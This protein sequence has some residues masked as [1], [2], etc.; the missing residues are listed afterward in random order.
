MKR[1]LY[2]TLSLGFSVFPDSR[3]LPQRT[4]RKHKGNEGLLVFNYSVTKLPIYQISL[5]P[6][7]LCPPNSTQGH[8]IH[9]RI[10]RGSQP[11]NGKTRPQAGDSKPKNMWTAGALACDSSMGTRPSRRAHVWIAAMICSWD[12][13]HLTERH[14]H[15]RG[16]EKQNWQNQEK[17]RVK[18]LRQRS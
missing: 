3:F 9:P 18:K 11:Q 16:P 15:G 12:T 14:W 8:P 1:T 7:P 5:Y 6:A 2:F 4:Q 10:G 13:R 17:R